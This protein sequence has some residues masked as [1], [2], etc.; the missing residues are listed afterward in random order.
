[1]KKTVMFLALILFLFSPAFARIYQVPSAFIATIQG[2]I[3]VAMDGDTVLVTPGIYYENINFKGKNILVAS[4]FIFDQNDSTIQ[5]TVIDGGN[6]ASVVTFNSGEDST[7]SIQGFTITH[8]INTDGGGIFC[9]GSSPKITHNIIREN[10]AKETMYGPVRHFGAGICCFDCSALIEYNR[11]INNQCVADLE[12][13]GGGGGIFYWGNRSPIIR[14]NS[15]AFNRVQNPFILKG[16]GG[17]IYYFSDSTTAS[18]YNNTITNNYAGEGGGGIYNWT[19]FPGTKIFN[20]IVAFNSEGIRTEYSP[21]ILFRPIL[22]Y[23]DVL[24]NLEG[25]FYGFSAEVG[26]TTWGFNRNGVPCDSFHNIIRDPLF[27]DTADFDF[28]LLITSPCIDAGDPSSPMDPDSTIADIGAFYYPHTPTF[29][30]G[31]ERNIPGEFE[32]SQNYPNPFNPTTRIQF[33]V[34]SLEFGNPAHT[35]LKVYNILGQL[36]RTLV[37]EEKMPG[38]YEIN[39]DGNNDSGKE[40]GSGIYFYQLRTRDY[41]DTKKMV[42]L[43]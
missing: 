6:K 8:G 20:N 27:V 40:V 38:N 3:N 28:N 39:W 42:L 37:D 32:L 12:V 16:L 33:R 1:M 24:G 18:I 17:G 10:I 11:I 4:N 41:T 25:N 9:D 13:G 34:S 7:A 29:V 35:T 15:I 5:K 23:N 30:K 26:D 2:G 31:D 21:N 36:V 22:A 19:F 43:R 14:Y